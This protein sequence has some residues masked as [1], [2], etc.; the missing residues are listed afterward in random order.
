MSIPF[1]L[2]AV[3]CIHQCAYQFINSFK[4]CIPVLLFLQNVHTSSF[5]SLKYAYQSFYQC[6]IC[7]PGLS[8]MQ[9]CVYQVFHYSKMCMPALSKMCI[10][11]R[12]FLNSSKMCLLHLLLML[13]VHIMPFITPKCVYQFFNSSK[14][15]IPTLSLM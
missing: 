12:N 1:L 10:S 15:Y 9:K 14:M 7:I 4:K 8:F 3:V 11:V 2:R 6:K 13:N 5:I